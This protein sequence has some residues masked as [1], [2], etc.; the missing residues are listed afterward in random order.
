MLAMDGNSR[1]LGYAIIAIIWLVGLLVT[2]GTMMGDCTA[3][4][5][6]TCPTATDR[7]LEILKVLIG[8]AVL[9][10]LIWFGTR[11]SDQGQ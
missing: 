9:T 11:N 10:A 1:H 3:V 2:T 8:A 7:S 4:G 6:A 5:D